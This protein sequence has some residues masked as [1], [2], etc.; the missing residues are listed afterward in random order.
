MSAECCR[1]GG[2][3]PALLS[4]IGGK[5]REGGGGLLY[6]GQVGAQLS[7]TFTFMVDS[8]IPHQ[9]TDLSSCPS[10]VHGLVL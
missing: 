8:Q 4:D 3:R 1:R 2:A 6:N 7:Y 9:G 5:E 10:E